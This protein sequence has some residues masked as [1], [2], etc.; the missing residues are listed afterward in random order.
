[1]AIPL[2]VDP[3]TIPT[4][5]PDARGRH[6]RHVRRPHHRVPRIDDRLQTR[7]HRHFTVSAKTPGL[8]TGAWNILL[9]ID[10]ETGAIAEWD[11]GTKV[12]DEVVFAP[13]TSSADE[14]G[15]YVT[16]RTDLETMRSDWVALD[17][18]DIGAGPVAAVELPFRVPAGLLGNWFRP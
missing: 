11:S 17:A 7:A 1:M 14:H 12:F 8:P 6:G 18:D 15:Y 13:A 10:T 5:R 2:P 16:F 4:H 3:A 9:R